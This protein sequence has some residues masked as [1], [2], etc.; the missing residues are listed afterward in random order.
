MKLESSSSSLILSQT[1]IPDVFFTEYLSQANGNFVKIYLYLIFLSKYNK[2]V[3]VTDLAKKL[4]LPLKDIQDGI[5]YWE[6]QGLLIRKN[7]GYILADIQEI[8][9]NKIYKPKI[10]ISSEEVSKIPENKKRADAIE[11]INNEFFQGVM[12]PSLYGDIELW[13]KK[14]NFDEEVMIALFRYC[15][16]NSALHTSYIATV[17]EGWY[18]DGIKTYNDLDQY[19]EKREKLKKVNNFVKRKLRLNRNLTE[20]E[21]SYIEKWTNEFKYETDIIEKALKL[22][23]LKSNPSLKYVDQILTD[24]HAK[25]LNTPEQIDK[26]LECQKSKKKITSDNNKLNI[27]IKKPNFSERNYTNLNSLYSN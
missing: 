13:F 24:W 9:L 2:D 11:T 20:F 15:Y 16:N 1:V 14:Y 17:A 18:N 22:T 7:Q 10:S 3:K 21:E 19:F 4:E 23:A 26:Y 8:E 5:K 25:D 6:N 12:S 27:Q